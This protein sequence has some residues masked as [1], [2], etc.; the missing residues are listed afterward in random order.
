MT[1][2][3]IQGGRASYHEQ[4]A[5]QL[6]GND[7]E[8]VYYGTHGAVFEALRDGKVDTI[9]VAIANNR[10]Q[11][12]PEVRKRLMQADAPY[13]ITAETYLRIEHALLGIPGAELEDI[14]SIH[15]QAPALG[16]CSEFIESLIPDVEVVE[17]A[18]TAGSAEKVAMSNDRSMAAIA[19]TAAKVIY[20]LEIIQAGVQDDIDNVT[21]FVE[22]RRAA[23]LQVEPE[24]NRAA[25]MFHMPSGPGSL[26][27]LTG[28][29]AS[30]GISL[31]DIE[32]RYIPNSAFA[33]NFYVEIE[34]GLGEERTQK[35]LEELAHN[36]YRYDILGSYTAAEIPITQEP[37]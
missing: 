25:M 21:R 34:A 16:Q 36:G 8:L 30:A 2:V 4:A 35:A 3:G 12:I 9:L 22:V 17:E 6:Y 29:F 37:K 19:S 14:R 11:S 33:M 26:H 5:Q 10:F 20:G 31:S 13:V 7:V 18:D 23:D 28:P 1:K 24:H 15:S 32:R 27:G